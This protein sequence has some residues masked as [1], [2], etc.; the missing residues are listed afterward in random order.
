MLDIEL[1]Y[2]EFQIDKKE[3]LKSNDTEVPNYT[4]HIRNSAEEI[5]NA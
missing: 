3:S 2:Q 1:I 5:I 4:I